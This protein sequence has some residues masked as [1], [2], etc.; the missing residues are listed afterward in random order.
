MSLFLLCTIS[1]LSS[2]L[3]RRGTARFVAF[4][5]LV[6]VGNFLFQILTGTALILMAF[7]SGFLIALLYARDRKAPPVFTALVV[8]GV[9][10]A[11]VLLVLPYVRSLGSVGEGSGAFR[12]F[13]HVGTANFLSMVAPCVALFPFS[14]R[15]IRKLVTSK[16]E[17][18][19][20]AAVWSA[21]LFVVAI[22]FNA[23]GMA[24]VKLAFFFL[25]LLLPFVAWELIDSVRRTKGARL[26]LLSAWILI[27]FVVPTALTVR[28]F[29]L[30]KP[31]NE[32]E[33]HAYVLNRADRELI[34]WVKA[35][36]GA[37]AVILEHKA[38]NIMPVYAERRSFYSEHSSLLTFG[39][40]DA[41]S[42]RYANIYDQV[43]SAKPLKKEDVEFLRQR[44]FDLFVVV[45]DIDMKRSPGI[46]A[47]L[48]A[49]PEDF[50]KVYQGAAGTI[51]RFRK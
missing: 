8:P 4:L 5:V 14:Y 12:Q 46:A 34:D 6:F 33:A 49:S 20:I 1:V 2:G 19:R 32:D 40:D 27:L 13:I 42:K 37:N 25:Q 11:S 41:R 7:G 21:S 3:F 9:A 35:N 26:L 23:G 10:V 44:G 29:L 43:Y 38:Y 31:A 50:E 45:W 30:D 39:Y 18:W 22:F 51:Y 48:D 24:E 36:T 17:H 15:A 28:G 47:E 16:D